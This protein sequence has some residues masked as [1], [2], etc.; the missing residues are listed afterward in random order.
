[1]NVVKM[2]QIKSMYAHGVARD[3]EYRKTEQERT[4]VGLLT[5]SCGKMW[6]I[7]ENGTV[8]NR[9]YLYDNAGRCGL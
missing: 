2:D 4:S 7:R 8:M 5:E 6:N 1:M 9:A 3:D